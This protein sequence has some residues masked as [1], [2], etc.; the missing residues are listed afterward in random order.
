MNF[1]YEAKTGVYHLL[2]EGKRYERKSY[3]AIKDLIDTL[4]PNMVAKEQDKLRRSV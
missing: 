3:L 1:W 2:F 4:I